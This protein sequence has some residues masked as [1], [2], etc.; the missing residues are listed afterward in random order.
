MEAD[1]GSKVCAR[2]SKI[3]RALATEAI[4]RGDDLSVGNLVEPAHEFE[5]VQQPPAERGA[6]AAQP[7]HLAKAGVAWAPAEFLAEQVGDERIVAELD[8]LPAETDLQVRYP[9][10]RRNQDDGRPRLAVAPPDENAFQLLPFETVRD[11]AV[12]AHFNSLASSASL[13]TVFMLRPVPGA[14]PASRSFDRPW[15]EG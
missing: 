6:V 2:P 7:V 14:L 5:H 10:H 13:A 9:H 1:G 12:L 3:E 11:R 15:P 4:A 8:Q